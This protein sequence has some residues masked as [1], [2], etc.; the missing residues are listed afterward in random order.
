MAQYSRFNVLQQNFDVG[1]TPVRVSNKTLTDESS[2]FGQSVAGQSGA[3]ASVDAFSAGISTI[4]GLTGMTAN[5]VGR[6]LTVAGAATPA[7]NGTF[8]IVAFNS[9][10]SV[11]IANATGVSPDA[12]DGSILWTER[13]PYALADDLNFQRTD[14]AAIKGVAYDAAI[15]TFTRPTATGTPVAASLANLAGKSTDAQGFIISRAFKGA[16]AVAATTKITITS[17]GNLKHASATDKSGVPCFDV[18]PYVGDFKATFV[19][20]Q[21]SADGTELLVKAGGHA[22]E[23]IFGVTNN[24]ASTSPNSVEIL[25][26][27]VPLGGD[28]ASQSTAYTWEGSQVTAIDLF[29]GFFS[30]LDQL[31]ESSFRTMQTLGVEE[32]GDLRQDIND[33]QTLIGMA[34]GETDLSAELTNTGADYVFSTISVTPTVVE[35]LNALNLEIGNR[36]YTGPILTDGG[37]ITGSLQALSDAINASN[38]TRYIERL[39]SAAAANTSHLLPG[40]ATY[41]P[42]GSF[43][44]GNLWV[45]WSGLLRDPGAV[46]N[47]DDY[48]ETDSTHI[49]PYYQVGAGQHINY[50]VLQ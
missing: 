35:A 2:G 38:V 46:V 45:F 15:P 21:A 3:A 30:R 41:T 9:A 22:G 44:G 19:S 40:G 28:I 18:A 4:G 49:T 11:D 43:N 5:S 10:T 37:D 33:I 12:N 23:K 34:D 17:A 24:G 16:T 42:D 13:D 32:N 1:G 36:T 6:F 14:R 48:S 27:S 31:D 8:L 20:I 7:N 47:G 26:Y 39:G 25:W 29:Y 50:F